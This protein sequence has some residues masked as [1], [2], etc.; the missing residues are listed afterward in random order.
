[1]AAI[2]LLDNDRD[3]LCAMRRFLRDQPCD[4][5]IASSTEMAM[6]MFRRCKFDIVV[7][8]RTLASRSRMDLLAWLAKHFP[9]TVQVVMSGN[10]KLETT[11]MEQDQK[12]V[13]RLLAKPIADSELAF[14][15]RDSLVVC[16]SP[17]RPT[18]RRVSAGV[19][20]ATRKRQTSIESLRPVPYRRTGR[21]GL[22]RYKSIQFATTN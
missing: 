15:I 4:L 1:M 9:D 21:R 19:R 8:D 12:H 5:F 7:V 6:D 10:T 17:S 2:L 22:V 3:L 16:K 20:D 11:E 18:D 13:F 14:A